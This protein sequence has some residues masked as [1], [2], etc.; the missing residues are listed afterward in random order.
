MPG[1]VIG[2]SAIAS[3]LG[4]YL[5]GRSQSKAAQKYIDYL[6]SQ[7]QTFLTA[8]DPI[9]KRLESYATGN[10]GYDPETLQAMRAGSYEDYGQ[11]LSEAGDVIRKASVSPGGVYTTGR[12]DRAGRMLG[13]NIATRRA[14]SLR[15]ITKQNADLATSNT[16][17]AIGALP[18]FEPGLPATQ[19][20][21]L[22]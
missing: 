18:T 19:V 6:N 17:F 15:D 5:S 10:V 1:W 22:S 11:G 14:E 3:G 20:P 13:E 9:R 4:S 7:R 12:G 2:G 8:T 16:R 21:D